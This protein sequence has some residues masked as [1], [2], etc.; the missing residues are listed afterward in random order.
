MNKTANNEF[1]AMHGVLI[2]SD[3]MPGVQQIQERINQYKYPCVLDRVGLDDSRSLLSGRVLGCNAFARIRIVPISESQ[4]DMLEPHYFCECDL[5]V[6]FGTGG[7]YASQ[8]FRECCKQGIAEMS[9]GVVWEMDFHAPSTCQS[10]QRRIYPL[11]AKLKLLKAIGSYS[12]DGIVSKS[13]PEIGGWET[14]SLRAQAICGLRCAGMI[15]PIQ[16]EAHLERPWC[17]QATE[18]GREFS[19]INL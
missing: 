8:I 18:I 4:P 17:F 19:R 1:H 5:N 12:S 16:A 9:G 3:R 7:T 2:R 6:M 13:S 15:E 14:E 10:M 11:L